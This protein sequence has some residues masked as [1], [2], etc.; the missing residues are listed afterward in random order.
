M[1]NI[2]RSHDRMSC[3][4]KPFVAQADRKRLKFQTV[5]P[6]ADKLVDLETH[7]T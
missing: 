2:R 3:L 6:E 5:D 7:S 1:L 4:T